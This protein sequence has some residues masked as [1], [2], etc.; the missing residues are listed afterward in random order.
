[1]R[2]LLTALLSLVAFVV[3]VVIGGKSSKSFTTHIGLRIPP[4]ELGCFQSGEVQT[5]EGHLLKVFMCPISSGWLA[6]N[7]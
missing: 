2:V 5:G 6:K 7:E 3:V 4:T 1:M